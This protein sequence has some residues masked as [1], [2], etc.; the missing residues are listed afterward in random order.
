M[1]VLFAGV[2][3][4]AACGG[5]GGGSP[6]TDA[7]STDAITT[8]A[9]ATDAS[10]PDAMIDASPSIDASGVGITLHRA[11]QVVLGELPWT[12]AGQ[13]Q[14]ID[15]VHRIGQDEPVTAWRVIA[16][17]TLDKKLADTV[18]SKARIATV[19][20]DGEEIS[21][22]D[23]KSLSDLIAELVAR[24]MRVAIPTTEEG[25]AAVAA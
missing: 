6:V 12:A 4:G 11:S 15:R 18:A 9:P 20:I 19:A 25:S 21:E 3:T 13:D 2:G 16:D 22:E 24:A 14:A 23:A 17:D 1:V 7:A 10:E 8:D 5:G